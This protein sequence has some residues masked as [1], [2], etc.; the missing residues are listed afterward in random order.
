[1]G[2]FERPSA[3][4]SCTFKPVVPEASLWPIGC[5][6]VAGTER[7]KPTPIAAV[8]GGMPAMD[9]NSGIQGPRVRD[10][11]E[12]RLLTVPMMQ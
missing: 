11:F 7:S 8:R 9:R 4:G 1:M 5:P 10:Q 2:T 3:G 12:A 6:E